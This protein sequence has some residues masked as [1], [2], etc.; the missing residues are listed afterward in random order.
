MSKRYRPTGLWQ[1]PV[2]ALMN[3]SKNVVSKDGVQ[4]SFCRIFVVEELLSACSS[5]P[6]AL[7]FMVE[8]L[9]VLLRRDDDG[10][11]ASSV[12]DVVR[13]AFPSA[14]IFFITI[15]Q[16]RVVGYKKRRRRFPIKRIQSSINFLIH[17]IIIIVQAN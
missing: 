2:S 15:L 3:D 13:A 5:C 7:S 17:I 11:D 12:N 10:D 14:A 6:A 16:T 8:S 9:A 1:A 4:F